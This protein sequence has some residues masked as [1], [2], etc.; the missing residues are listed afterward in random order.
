MEL[1]DTWVDGDILFSKT[2]N[3]SD[4]YNAVNNQIN[5][6]VKGE[7][8]FVATANFSKSPFI[9]LFNTIKTINLMVNSPDPTALDFK[10]YKI[11]N[12]IGDYIFNSFS[13]PSTYPHGLTYDG[14]N[15][16]SCDYNSEKIY[17]HSGVSSTITDSFSNPGSSPRGLTYDGTN[18]ISC[19]YSSDKIYLR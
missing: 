11:T 13:S 17:V 14:T 3:D 19:D 4:G 2:I 8:G 15:L 10:I 6:S 5:K 16:I 7:C 12:D 1:K 9:Y 18:L